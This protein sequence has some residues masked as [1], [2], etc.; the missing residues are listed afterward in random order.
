MRNR[1]YWAIGRACGLGVLAIFASLQPVSTANAACKG[2][3]SDCYQDPELG[4]TFCK[5]SCVDIVS[6]PGGAGCAVVTGGGCSFT[7]FCQS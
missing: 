7:G 5:F 2:C 1:L 3:K 6:G 4:V